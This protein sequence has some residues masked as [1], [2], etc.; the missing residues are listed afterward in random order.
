MEWDIKISGLQATSPFRVDIVQ[1]YEVVPDEKSKDNYCPVQHTSHSDPDVAM[2]TVH[3]L[4]KEYGSLR[5]SE[6][7]SAFSKVGHKIWGLIKRYG[8][9]VASLGV[10]A[11]TGGGS[12]AMMEALPMA[13]KALS[14]YR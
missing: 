5:N 2:K 12:S 4:S 13:G 11:Y 1:Y 9:T 10:A 7:G 6:R 14:M 8:P 3:S